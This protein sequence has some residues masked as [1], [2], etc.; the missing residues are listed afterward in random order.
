MADHYCYGTR[1][2]LDELQAAAARFG[3]QRYRGFCSQELGIQ[4]FLAAAPQTEVAAIS[5]AIA[6]SSHS[7]LSIHSFTVHWRL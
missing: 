4:H 5:K 1:N 3:W 7:R 2:R 6:R